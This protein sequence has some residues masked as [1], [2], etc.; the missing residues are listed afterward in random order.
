MLA[1]VRGGAPARRADVTAYALT[2]RELDVLGLVGAGLNNTEVAAWLCLSLSTVK[3]HVSN[4][5]DRTGSRDRVQAA[6]L[7]IRAGLV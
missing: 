5:L 4:V 1:R 2:T 6:I 7:A 3:T